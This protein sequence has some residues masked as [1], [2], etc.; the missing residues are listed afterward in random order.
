M[1]VQC[2]GS[3]LRLAGL[4]GQGKRTFLAT[5]LSLQGTAGELWDLVMNTA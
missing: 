3:G 5:S 2:V 4:S 1:G